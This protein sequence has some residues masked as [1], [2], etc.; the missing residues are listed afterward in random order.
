MLEGIFVSYKVGKQA[1]TFSKGCTVVF[2]SMEDE[3]DTCSR[4]ARSFDTHLTN[5]HGS[6]IIDGAIFH[7]R[8]I[9]N[10]YLPGVQD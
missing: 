4:E 5:G 2:S 1:M 6:R 10:E 9:G 3:M 8:S 7:A